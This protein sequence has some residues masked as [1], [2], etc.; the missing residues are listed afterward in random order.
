MCKEAIPF[1]A[2]T[3]GFTQYNGHVGLEP[4]F[5]TCSHPIAL[6]DIL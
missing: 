5:N 1:T 6:K 2:L 3:L 4:N